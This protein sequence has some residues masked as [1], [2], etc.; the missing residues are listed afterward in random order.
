MTRLPTQFPQKR[1]RRDRP[2]LATWGAV[3]A[4]ICIAVVGIAFVTT[5]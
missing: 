5:K 3:I 4:L 2:M 1:E